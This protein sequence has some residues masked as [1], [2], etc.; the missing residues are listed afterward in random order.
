MEYTQ[1]QL[2]DLIDA[3]ED[4]GGEYLEDLC[5]NRTYELT[6]DKIK[7]PTIA[8]CGNQTLFRI[9]YPSEVEGTNAAVLEHV[10]L[11][12]VCDDMGS[13]PRYSPVMG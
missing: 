10:T 2:Y 13:M 11:C 7:P 12:A 6:G 8:G 9:S 1:S 4:E 3:V 5:S